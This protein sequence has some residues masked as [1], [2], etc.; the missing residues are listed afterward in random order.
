MEG[1]ARPR[2]AVVRIRLTSTL[3]RS[4]GRQKQR[5]SGLGGST[6]DRVSAILDPATPHAW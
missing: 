6:S 3:G 4:E 5:W 1:S 2:F